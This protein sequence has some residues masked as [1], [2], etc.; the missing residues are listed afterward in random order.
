MKELSNSFNNNNI[1]NKDCDGSMEL[2]S[3][4]N[5]YSYIYV[6]RENT[7]G[8]IDVIGYVE[9]QQEAANWVRHSSIMRTDQRH[10]RC[11]LAGEKCSPLCGE[12]KI[13]ALE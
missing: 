13:K 1:F 7:G 11:H 6:L 12:I 8:A 2:S 4:T 10:L 3:D 5:S 9:T